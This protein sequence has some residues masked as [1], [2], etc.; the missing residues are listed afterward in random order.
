W[1]SIKIAE[2][3]REIS[4]FDSLTAISMLHFQLKKVQWA[5]FETG[6]G[7]RLDSTNVLL[8]KFCV[9]TPVDLDH[10]NILGKKIEEIAMEKGGIIKPGVPVYAYVENKNARSVIGQIAKKNNSP[11]QFFNPPRSGNYLE[12]NLAFARWMLEDY[13]Q[14][15]ADNI[16]I[17]VKGRLETLSLN[18]GIV[19]D[20]AHNMI[21]INALSDW[22]NRQ[23]GSWNIFINTMKERDLHKF[24]DA[25]QKNNN[26]QIYLFPTEEPGYYSWNDVQDNPH[27][28]HISKK[29]LVHIFADNSKSHLICGSMRIYPE[30]RTMLK[31]VSRLSTQRSIVG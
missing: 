31:E 11:V 10:Q 24:I 16:D 2:H 4:F 9:I 19:F 23:E 17:N 30:V 20:S 12:K 21:S 26:A 22:L 6:L 1:N 14:K 15:P 8:P 5:V 27:I 3:V 18:P 25:L 7:G 28:H 13:F 29:N